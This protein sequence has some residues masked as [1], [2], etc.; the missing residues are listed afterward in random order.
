M[1]EVKQKWNHRLNGLK[2][3]FDVTVNGT[4]VRRSSFD[5]KEGAEAALDAV[6]SYEMDVDDQLVGGTVKIHSVGAMAELVVCADL[7]R[8]GYDVFRSMSANAA[9]DLIAGTDSGRLCRV[10]VKSAV[11][12]DGKTRFKM[13]RFDR[14]KHDILAL[15]FLRE[16]RIEYSVDPPKWFDQE[17]LSS[18]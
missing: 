15:V 5:T 9:C 10:E 7:L 16:G 1:P 4:R 13:H 6:Q 8:R 11:K 2:W 17:N 12:R 18:I 14:T 3:A